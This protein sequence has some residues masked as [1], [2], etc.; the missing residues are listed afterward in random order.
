MG[1][2]KV[3]SPDSTADDV[4]AKPAMNA[5]SRMERNIACTNFFQ[6]WLLASGVAIE[7]P[8]RALFGCV[9]RGASRMAGHRYS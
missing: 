3:S 5:N 1:F 4:L 2:V 6:W 8:A 9:V 7:N